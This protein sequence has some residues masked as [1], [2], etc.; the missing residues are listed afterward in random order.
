MDEQLGSI[1]ET[2]KMFFL[3]NERI[4]GIN[5]LK[6]YLFSL[7]ETILLETNERNAWKMNDYFK[8]KQNLFFERLKK[9]PNI[10]GCLRTMKE[11]NKKN[12]RMF[13]SLPGT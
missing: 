8:S 5:S 13:P 10:I 11:R 12:I 1:R 9:K 3:P 4:F 2:N 7:N 6:N